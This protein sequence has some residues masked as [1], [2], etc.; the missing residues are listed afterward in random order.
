MAS[1]TLPVYRSKN[2]V[3]PILSD[4]AP[5]PASSLHRRAVVAIVVVVVSLNTYAWCHTGRRISCL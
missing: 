5:L 2:T 4:V 1:F 3:T